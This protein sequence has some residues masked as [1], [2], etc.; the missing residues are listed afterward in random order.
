MKSKPLS[1]GPSKKHISTRP[2]DR[3]TELP[4]SCDFLGGQEGLLQHQE[5]EGFSN[6]KCDQQM[7]AFLR[8]FVV[9]VVLLSVKL[10]MVFQQLGSWSCC[11][12]IVAL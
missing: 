1:R 10:P 5:S 9:L 8:C 6:L 11:R 2:V 12:V 7:N 3:G 4:R